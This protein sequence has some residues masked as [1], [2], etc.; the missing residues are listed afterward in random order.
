MIMKICPAPNMEYGEGVPCTACEWAKFDLWA[1]RPRLP[2]ITVYLVR[3]RA[4]PPAARRRLALSPASDGEKCGRLHSAYAPH[5]ESASRESRVVLPRVNP[6]PWTADAEG[7]RSVPRRRPCHAPALSR[8][9]DS[10]CR[11]WSPPASDASPSVL[12]IP[13]QQSS[14]AHRRRRSCYNISVISWSR[15]P[16]RPWYNT[17]F[18]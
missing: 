14:P 5:S 16:L 2:V 11:A 4:R 6:D 10:S 3:A 18:S 8:Q 9:R 1:E 17:C 15:N 13:L 12:T 7:E